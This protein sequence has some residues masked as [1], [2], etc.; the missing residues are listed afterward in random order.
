[1]QPTSLS[2]AK[3]TRLFLSASL[4]PLSFELAGFVCSTFHMRLICGPSC[5]R[6]RR[7]RGTVHRR[8]RIAPADVSARVSCAMEVLCLPD[9]CNLTLR[10]LAG[11][12]HCKASS[13]L[14]SLRISPG[15]DGALFPPL[16]YLFQFRRR[17]CVARAPESCQGE[18]NCT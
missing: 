13:P 4:S 16:S 14:Y 9:R 18:V 10:A 6:R 7:P 12:E 5:P 1:M 11:M 2:R 17:R 15:H 3:P 8:I